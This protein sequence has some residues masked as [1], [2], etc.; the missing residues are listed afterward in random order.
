MVQ[1]TEVLIVASTL[2]DNDVDSSEDDLIVVSVGNPMGGIVTK[3]EGNITFVSTGYAGDP[4]DFEYVVENG[5]GTSATGNVYV[6]VTALTPI[7]AYI[8]HNEGLLNEKLSS[9]QPPSVTDIFNTWGRY[10]GNYFYENKDAPE[11]STNAAA[12]QLLS[13]PDRVSMP[14]NAYPYN[15]FVSPE[16]LQTPHSRLPCARLMAITTPSGWLSPLSALTG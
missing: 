12:W 13:D 3:V 9:Y 14:L 10:D 4:A 15:G 6:N 11:I 2:A 5:A 16:K 7:E 8:Y 1:G